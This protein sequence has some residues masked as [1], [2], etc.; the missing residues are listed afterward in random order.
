MRVVVLQ[1]HLLGQEFQKSFSL[2][3]AESQ[4]GLCGAAVWYLDQ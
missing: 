1:T 3:A 4:Y 2:S